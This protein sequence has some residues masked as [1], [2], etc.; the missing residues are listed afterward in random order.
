VT[1]TAEALTGPWAANVR[2]WF[3]AVVP[4]SL[5]VVIQEIVTPLPHA[6]WIALSVLLQL[7]A[8]TAWAAIVAGLARRLT[9][10]VPPAA[11]GILW[12]G[13]GVLR[14]VVGAL[15]A[16]QSGMPAE[17]GYR[18]GFWTI[19]TLCW[20]PLLTYA[21][22]QWD[23]HRR[24]LADRAAMAIA[25][26]AASARAA[27]GD[28]ARAHRLALA[29]DDALGPGLDEIRAALRAAGTG[30]DP[31]SAYEI[32]ARLDELADRTAAYTAP[33]PVSLPQR[34]EERVSVR[35]ASLEFE[36]RR[37]VFAALLTAAD[38]A[39]LLLPEAYRNDGWPAVAEMAVAIFVATV[40]L[41]A[42]YG[43]LRPGRF[44]GI[45]RSI[46]SRIGVTLAGL[47]GAGTLVIH[48]WEPFQ[49]H[50][51]LLFAAFPLVFIA[52][53]SA[54]AT[55][56]ALEATNVDLRQRA[57][58]DQE[59]L[60]SLGARVRAADTVA[61][62]RLETLVR[63]ELNG[64]LAGCAMALGFLSHGDIAGEARADLVASVLAQLDAAAEELHRA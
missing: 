34:A 47:V 16:L 38:T 45:Q 4:A 18:V 9:G 20:M 50:D 6:G 32:A 46:G 14:G 21:L 28:G 27:E 30:I 54:T 25:L 41:M 55:A 36:L 37:P 19:V 40:V 64:R 35:T 62:V 13:I 23:Q 58:D 24:L 52:G 49:A 26:D 29:A 63:G 44:T 57:T 5:I 22:A 39:P 48:D 33:D 31:S 7:L 8:V 60:A 2:G 11:L 10:R 53:A 59:A 15:V 43:I 17:W 61:A 12:L 56:V 51:V 1:T 3:V 42:T